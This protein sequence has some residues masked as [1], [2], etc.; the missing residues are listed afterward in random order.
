VDAAV[1]A[2]RDARGQSFDVA[3]TGP[4]TVAGDGLPLTGRA[5]L[6]PGR[7]AAWVSHRV[8]E[9]WVDGE[10]GTFDV[11]GAL[12]T[13]P[14]DRTRLSGAYVGWP[15]TPA[16][17]T[18]WGRR[19]GRAVQVAGEYLDHRRWDWIAQPTALLAAYGDGRWTAPLVL[20]VPLLADPTPQ[21]PAPSLAGVA[22]GRYDASFRALARSLAAHG[23][24]ATTLR[25]GWEANSPENYAWSAVPDPDAYRA[26]FR[27]VVG[28]VRA[29]APAARFDWGLTV[30]VDGAFDAR[31]CYPGDDVVDVVGLDVYDMSPQPLAADERWDWYQCAPGGLDEIAEFAVAHGKPLGVDEWAVASRTWNGGGDDPAFVE[32]FRAWMDRWPVAHEIYNEVEYPYSDGR[33]LLGD[34]NPRAAAEYVAQFGD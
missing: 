13:P 14:R 1:I 12:P 9:R 30:A 3:H 18:A 31:R 11:P 21:D 27:R 25:L 29:E 19:R 26:A 22:Q 7:Y 23:L 2:V 4:C 17:L 24:G 10:H 32:R 15:Q 16:D 34:R 33:L 8:G 20:S 28:V 5:M 6:A